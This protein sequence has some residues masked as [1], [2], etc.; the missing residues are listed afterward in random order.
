VDIVWMRLDLSS[1]NIRS[2]LSVSRYQLRSYYSTQSF[3][4]Q[5][6]S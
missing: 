5:I 4:S 3:L 6:D 1:I 2:F